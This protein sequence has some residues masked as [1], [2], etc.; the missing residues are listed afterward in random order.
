V[1]LTQ[2]LRSI[3]DELVTDW[4]ALLPAAGAPWESITSDEREQAC[5]KLITAVLSSLNNRSRGAL[6]HAAE[7]FV[8]TAAAE[9]VRPVEIH[10]ALHSL[11]ELYYGAVREAFLTE[12]T[13]HVLAWERLDDTLD[14]FVIDTADSCD[15]VS[16]AVHEQR[17]RKLEEQNRV[18]LHD[19][20]RDPLTGLYN[21]GY[22]DERLVQ[23][24]RRARRRE[25]T[26]ALIMFDIDHFKSINDRF[27]HPVGDTAIRAVGDLAHRVVR[28]EDLSARIGGDEFALILPETKS[29]DAVIPAERLRLAV[30]SLDIGSNLTLTLS[31]G[32]AAFQ[33]GETEL[34]LLAR[35]DKAMYQSKNR[36]G[37]AITVLSAA[38]TDRATPAT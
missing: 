18:L 20:A 23:E 5:R 36:G 7:A 15:R 12:P 4:A 37:N 30:T 6:R 19:V 9:G 32:V 8:R 2:T 34:E 13:L 11:R 3:S 17:L 25:H 10:R 33:A 22:F 26:L 35:A 27:G 1:R 31:I 14:E 21:R 16:Y 24:V 38:A 28:L 29:D